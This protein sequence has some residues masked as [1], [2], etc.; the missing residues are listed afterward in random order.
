MSRLRPQSTIVC[1]DAEPIRRPL[2]L[3]IG[4][5]SH[6]CYHSNSTTGSFQLNDGF[7]D[8]PASIFFLLA[9]VGIF[10]SPLEAGLREAVRLRR[11][12]CSATAWLCCLS[13]A[14]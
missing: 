5:T 14:E 4:H 7:H 3:P 9:T 2:G 1:E 12:L 8:P 6:G 13:F 10:S 11:N